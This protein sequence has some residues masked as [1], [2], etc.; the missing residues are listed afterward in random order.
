[1]KEI[2]AHK[3]NTLA[4]QCYDYLQNCIIDGTLAPGQKLKVEA[5][6]EQLG[7][8]QSPI[9][10]ALSRLVAS[11]L[12]T[13]QDNKGFWVAQV[14]EED[15]RDTYRVFV[16]IELLALKQ[17]IELGDDAWESGIVAALHNLALVETRQVET[18]VQVWIERNYSFHLALIV[19]C[20]SPLLLDLREQVY[21][22]FH[23]YCWL[24]YDALNSRL[25]F[26]HEEHKSLA[27]AVISRNFP[28]A[29]K[30]MTHHVYRAFETVVTRLKQ[31][32]TL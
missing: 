19:G 17:A 27:Q 22:R 31:N 9:R 7:I 20:N 29:E 15:I 24:S 3:D 2:R 16:Q 11:G 12:V 26:S 25:E 32:N 8:G 1:M 21:R 28:E 6:K 14:S 4:L 30:I 10:E 13:V 18:S 23:R 5:L